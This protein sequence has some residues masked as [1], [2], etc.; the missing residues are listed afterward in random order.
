[1]GNYFHACESLV[2]FKSKV[3]SF[4]RPDHKYIFDIHVTKGIRCIFQL[5]ERVSPLNPICTGVLQ[6]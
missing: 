6:E 1:M 5:R 3:N 4:V 2:N